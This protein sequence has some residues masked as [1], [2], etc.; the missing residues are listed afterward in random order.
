MIKAILLL[1]YVSMGLGVHLGV[2]FARLHI[3]RS[4]IYTFIDYVP[5]FILSLV[6]WPLLLYL[7]FEE[8]EGE[9]E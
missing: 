9:D 1:V 5:G 6:A 7:M 4:K 8:D 2:S 3:Y